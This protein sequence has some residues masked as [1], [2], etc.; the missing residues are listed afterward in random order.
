MRSILCL[1]VAAAL[2]PA[3]NAQQA[4]T[5]GQSALG[6]AGVNSMNCGGW[7]QVDGIPGNATMVRITLRAVGGQN[8]VEKFA[9]L[10]MT[11]VANGSGV[12]GFGWELSNPALNWSGDWSID[13]RASY[14]TTPPVGGVPP[15]GMSFWSDDITIPYIAP[16][17]PGSEETIPADEEQWD[18]APEPDVRKMDSP[19][20]AFPS[21]NPLAGGVTLWVEVDAEG[22]YYGVAS[23]TN[24]SFPAGSKL[25]ES[26]TVTFFAIEGEDTGTGETMQGA[27]PGPETYWFSLDPPTGLYGTFQAKVT[28]LVVSNDN[29]TFLY[30]Y[31]GSSPVVNLTLP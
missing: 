7:V 12:V 5:V 14:W 10:D 31:E 22:T 6:F 18:V 20:E 27:E 21:I 13:C 24:P 4:I 11:K 28:L 16:A 29:T 2:A 23:W 3:A 30:Q 17:P 19:P 8:T 26:C 25:Q 15:A 9:Y 1:I